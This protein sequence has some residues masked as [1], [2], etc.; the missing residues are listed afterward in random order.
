MENNIHNCNLLFSDKTELFL[1]IYGNSLVRQQSMD[2]VHKFSTTFIKWVK[3]FLFKFLG[4]T[5]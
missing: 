1:E 3:H 4:Q 2:Y 5:D